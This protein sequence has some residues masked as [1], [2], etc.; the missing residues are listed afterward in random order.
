MVFALVDFLLLLLLLHASRNMLAIMMEQ[1]PASMCV[2]LFDVANTPHIVII[3]LS[4][5]RHSAYL[6]FLLDGAW[7]H[8]FYSLLGALR[9]VPGEGFVRQN[10]IRFSLRKIITVF[11][12]QNTFFPFGGIEYG[13]E[14]V[15]NGKRAKFIDP[16]IA[17]RQSK[18]N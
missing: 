4:A 14:C 9:C 3:R 16:S 15:M 12:D 7:T 18:G 1:V 5:Y 13:I 17:E 2:Y 11:V 6:L 8:F 10:N